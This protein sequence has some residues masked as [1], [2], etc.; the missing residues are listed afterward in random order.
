VLDR[1]LQGGQLG[2]GLVNDLQR[3]LNL[4]LGDDE[5]WGETDDVLVSRLGL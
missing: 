2:H 4:F 1:A 5:G 3:L